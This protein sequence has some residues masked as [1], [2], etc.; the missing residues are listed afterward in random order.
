MELDRTN[1]T[2]MIPIGVRGRKNLRKNRKTANA[3]KNYI[4]QNFVR[5]VTELEIE[6]TEFAVIAANDDVVTR[7][8]H[9]HRR[10]PSNAWNQGFE[11]LLLGEII[12]PDVALGLWMRVFN[13]K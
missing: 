9:V 7:R 11:Q 6:P 1:G 5:L 4:P 10:D 12:D 3:K 8:M 2:G 13:R